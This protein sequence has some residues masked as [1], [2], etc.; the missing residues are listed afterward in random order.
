MGLHVFVFLLVVFLILT[1]TL[2]W[3]A[4]LVPSSAFLLKRGGQEQHAPPS[5]LAPLPR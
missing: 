2:L 5:A 4:F 1:L 3:R